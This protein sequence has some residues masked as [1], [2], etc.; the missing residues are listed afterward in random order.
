[1]THKTEKLKLE[2]PAVGTFGWHVEWGRNMDIIDAHP[3]ILVCTS[4]T[5]PATPWP[6][7]VIFET[8]TGEL[9]LF[10]LTWRK[11]SN[12][13]ITELANISQTSSIILRS[14]R[15]LFISASIPNLSFE[16]FI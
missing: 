9:F 15:I 2:T 1:M 5:R 12:T 6:G 14:H 13:H 16:V 10:N 3:G 11:V 7:Q 8:D 4:T